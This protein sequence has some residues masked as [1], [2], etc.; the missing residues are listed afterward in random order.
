M[1]RTSMYTYVHTNHT[2]TH[3]RDTGVQNSPPD[4]IGLP[5]GMESDRIHAS[6]G[7]CVWVGGWLGGVFVRWC[8]CVCVSLCLHASVFV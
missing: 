2:L 3:A 5:S 7:V 1:L 6:A 8:L 4:E